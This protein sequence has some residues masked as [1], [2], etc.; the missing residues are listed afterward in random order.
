MARTDCGL[1]GN[2][3]RSNQRRGF[4][5]IELLVVVA[6]I[7]L[8]ISI[9]LPS[10][11]SAREQARTA[12]CAANMKQVGIAFGSY[13]AENR[14]VY[15][16][17]YDYPYD[18]N[19]NV[20]Y[21]NQDASKPFGYVHWSWFLY[22][23]GKVADEAF[24]CPTI[25]NGGH[26]RT[27]PGT[28]GSD[29]EDGQI[30]DK[31]TTKGSSSSAQITDKQAR[32]MAFTANAAVVGRNKM[33]ATA[34]GQRQ[35]I[36]VQESKLRDTGR[37]V[38]VT[39][40]NKNWKNIAV[41]QGG[42]QYKSKSHRPVNVFWN[43]GSA[44][45]EYGLPENTRAYYYYDAGADA[46]GLFTQSAI[47]DLDY[48]MAA[49]DDAQPINEANMVGRHHGGGDKLGGTANFMY[50]DGH[51]ARK[52]IKQSLD[53]REWGQAVYSVSGQNGLALNGGDPNDVYGYSHIPT[54]Q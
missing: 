4:T 11:T 7:A 5:L 39:E 26:P 33:G 25:P 37:I 48:A 42:D 40:F 28:N 47:D 27:D 10:L 16:N 2:R 13:L 49:D 31:G 8:L 22:S 9:L 50:C 17:S 1:H 3:I 14:G 43:P 18:Y 51:V 53:L 35:N 52:T 23:N 46:Y 41:N 29:W 21:M 15:P 45:W 12:K 54:K 6:I 34:V 24:Q 30:D 19:G 36:F 20:N 38:L 44:W 32:R